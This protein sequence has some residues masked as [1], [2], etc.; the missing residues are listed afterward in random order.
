MKWFS[1]LYSNIDRRV[2]K[3]QP[4]DLALRYNIKMLYILFFGV[5]RGSV[6]NS[7]TEYEKVYKA[8]APKPK[9]EYHH[10]NYAVVS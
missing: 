5:K 1:C 10:L 8:K 4:L 7:K 9:N 3:Q 6:Y 2:T